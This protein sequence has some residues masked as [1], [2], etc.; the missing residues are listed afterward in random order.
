MVGAGGNFS[1]EL[2][3]PGGTLPTAGLTIVGVLPSHRRKGVLNK[4][5]RATLAD[6]V[7]AR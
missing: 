4:L 3:V 2:S 7:A 1:F 5:M 6:A